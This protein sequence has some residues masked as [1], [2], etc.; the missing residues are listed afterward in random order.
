MSNL[1]LQRPTDLSAADWSLWLDI[2]E[3]SGAYD[4]PYFCPEFVQAVAAVRADVEIAVISQAGQTVGFFPFQRGSLNLGK[5]VGGKLSDYHGPLLRHSAALDPLQLLHDCQLASWDFDHLVTSLPSF[6]PYLTLRD[7]S[8]WLDLTEGFEAYATQ[9]RAAGSDGVHNQARKTRKLAREVGPLDFSAA[10][11]DD[12]AFNLL[13]RWKSDQYVRTGLADVFSFSWTVELIEKL[14][15]HRTSDFSAPL[16]VLRAGGQLAAVALSLRSR[17]VLHV[18]F[19]AYNP[20]FAA[21]SPGVALLIRLAEEAQ[22]LGIRK[23]DLGR[24]NE[25]YKWSLASRSTEV[26]EGAITCP[27]LGT[28]L[29]SGWRRTRDWVAQSSLKNTTQLLRPI[30]NWLAY[31]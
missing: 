15:A 6:A 13:R 24:G 29:R 12:E 2:Q 27:A 8:P 17:G 14:R 19:T 18:W 31:H 5:P 25:R 26:A 10:A 16:T 7:R 23:I 4:S 9:R 21:Y 3:G 11:A 22:Q 1:Q 20:E 30:R 28:W